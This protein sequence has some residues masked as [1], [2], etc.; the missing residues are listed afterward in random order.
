MLERLLEPGPRLP[1]AFPDWMGVTKP[2]PRCVNH[3]LSS[4]RLQLYCTIHL[5]S[6]L[7]FRSDVSVSTGCRFSGTESMGQMCLCDQCLEQ[8]CGINFKRNVG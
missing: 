6:S 7:S 2:G 8:M 3:P 5:I 1:K 4:G